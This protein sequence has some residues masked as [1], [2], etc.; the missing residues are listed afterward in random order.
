MKV[1]RHADQRLQ[2][3]GIS[4]AECELVVRSPV[5]PTQP[6]DNGNLMF[7]RPMSDGRTLTV[8]TAPDRDTLVTAYWRS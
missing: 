8:V 3:R 2:E 5:G 7:S 6:G 1:S 4:I